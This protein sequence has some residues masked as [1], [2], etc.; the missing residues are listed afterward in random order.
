VAAG[1]VAGAAHGANVALT[2]QCIDVVF[3]WV[4]D[5]SAD[6]A[7]RSLR[8]IWFRTDTD[9]GSR[10]PYIRRLADAQKIRVLSVSLRA[11]AVF[12]TPDQN[13]WSSKRGGNACMAPIRPIARTPFR[14]LL[15][16]PG[17]V[18]DLLA[19]LTDAG[20]VSRLRICVAIAHSHK[21]EG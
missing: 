8:N 3:C 14:T 6:A 7:D 11:R 17:I 16:D 13:F 18:V 15:A 20:V 5:R 21:L 12:I 10:T 9:V 19:I 4:V 1:C 2:C